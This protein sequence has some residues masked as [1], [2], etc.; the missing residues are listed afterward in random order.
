MFQYKVGEI[1]TFF[2]FFFNIMDF[3]TMSSVLSLIS[4]TTEL[5]NK[6]NSSAIFLILFSLFK[7]TLRNFNDK[8]DNL[9]T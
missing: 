6:A 7:H 5:T 4:F 3:C 1:S 2:F 8:K 9:E